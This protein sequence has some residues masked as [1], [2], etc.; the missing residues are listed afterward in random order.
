MSIY[1]N[2]KIKEVKFSLNDAISSF[3]G[4]HKAF[5]AGPVDQRI[6]DNLNYDLRELNNNLSSFFHSNNNLLDEIEAFYKRVDKLNRKIG[7]CS[8]DRELRTLETLLNRRGR[9]LFTG[10]KANTVAKSLVG[11]ASQGFGPGSNNTLDS[12]NPLS[13]FKKKK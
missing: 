12:L 11:R 10:G 13:G 8:F 3:D 7:R 5:L 6:I 9:A 2:N 1:N 4:V